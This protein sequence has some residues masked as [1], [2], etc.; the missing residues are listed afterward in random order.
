MYVMYIFLFS[1]LRSRWPAY[2][3]LFDWINSWEFI[4]GRTV[5]LKDIKIVQFQISLCKNAHHAVFSV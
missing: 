1:P 5:E 4:F 3:I 2:L